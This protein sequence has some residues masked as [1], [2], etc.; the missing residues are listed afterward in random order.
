MLATRGSGGTGRTLLL[1]ADMDALPIQEA[2]EVEYRSL[3]DGRMHACGHDGHTAIALTAAA[4]FAAGGA[5]GRVRF[6][7][8]PAEEGGMGADRM[9]EE[10]V[11]DGVDAALGLHLWNWL[12]V[13]KVAVTPGP[14]MAAVDEFEI[15]VH[16]RGGHA[17]SPHDTEDPIVRAAALVQELQTIVSRRVDP[18]QTVVVS[19]TSIRG[20]SA[21]NVIPEEVTLTGTVRSFDEGV[22]DQVH[23][24]IRTMV[25]RCG[26]VEIDRRTHP[27]VNDREIA[28]VVRAAAVEAVGEE[29]VVDDLRSMTGEDFASFARAVPSCFFHVGSAGPDAFLHHHPRFDI[30]ERALAIG[31]EVLCGAAERY[32]ERGTA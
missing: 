14:V 27:L 19:V 22:R 21:F 23:R 18:V 11:L 9:I 6:A 1:R 7:F 17:A 16:G 28:A 24:E 8:Q 29:N 5:P 10:G 2:N 30:D 32:L 31:L 15:T 4:R 12:P 13:G 3:H 20:G 25:E 26:R